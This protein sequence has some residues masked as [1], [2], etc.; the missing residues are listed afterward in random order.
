VIASWVATFVSRETGVV[1]GVV[2]AAVLVFYTAV[3]GFLQRGVGVRPLRFGV[4][5][6]EVCV[7]TTTLWILDRTEG[8]AYAV[9]SW[10]PPQLFGIP[11]AAS[12][13]RLDARIPVSMGALAAAL[14][15]ALWFGVL[16]G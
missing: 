15:A 14:Y 3:H 9:A 6:F 10:V 11:L 8:P 1:L 7:A 4:P 13:L 12:I 16:R 2:V 5:L